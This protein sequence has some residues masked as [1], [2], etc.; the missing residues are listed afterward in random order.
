DQAWSM[1]PN[2][3]GDRQRA[4]I[5]SRNEFVMVA[6]NFAQAD[7]PFLIPKQYA[8]APAAGVPVVDGGGTLKMFTEADYAKLVEAVPGVAG[9]EGPHHG[10][11][12][13]HGDHG[14]RPQGQHPP[15]LPPAQQNPDEGF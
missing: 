7:K 4:L 10:W 8:L 6:E 9:E 15:P 14:D 13:R 1:N 12:G 2:A 3:N 5:E 11:H